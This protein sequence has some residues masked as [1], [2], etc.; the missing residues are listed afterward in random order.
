MASVDNVYDRRKFWKR[1]R[2]CFV[3]ESRVSTKTVETRI[4]GREGGNRGNYYMR[5]T[6]AGDHMA[7]KQLVEHSDITDQRT[8]IYFFFPA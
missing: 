1:F 3:F 2:G 7:G 5:C 8:E 4:D 6:C